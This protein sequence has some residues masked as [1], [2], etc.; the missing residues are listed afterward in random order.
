[1]LDYSQENAQNSVQN[2]PQINCILLFEREKLQQPKIGHTLLIVH[3]K[4]FCQGPY[5]MA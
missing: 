3:E 1:M 4:L 5:Q 2:V